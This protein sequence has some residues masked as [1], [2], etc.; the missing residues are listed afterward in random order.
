[1]RDASSERLILPRIKEQPEDFRVDEIPAYEPSGTGDHLFVRFEKRDRTTWDAVRAMA[2]ALGV[3]PRDAG[4]AGMKDKRAVTTQTASFFKARP[5]V[6]LK[7]ELPGIKVLSAVPHGQKLRTGHLAGNQFRIRILDVSAIQLQELEAKA[8]T[9]ITDGIPNAFG[10]QR[11]G[12]EGNN[13]ERARSWLK[14]EW[15]GPKDRRMRTFLFSALQAE[16]F[17]HVLEARWKDGTWNRALLGDVLKKHDTG[18][19]FTCADQAID[20]ER[21]TKGEVSPTGPIFGPKMREPEGAVRALEQSI[22]DRDLEGIDIEKT[23]SLGDGT[24][25]SLR[26]FARDLEVMR[27]EQVHECTVQFMLPK[28]SFATTVLA[29]L[30]P[31]LATDGDPSPE[32]D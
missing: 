3:D 24:R 20:G 2:E 6:A 4:F 21:A 30:V 27:G 14:G 13:A 32:E 28:G 9:V 12:R 31:G 11:F 26:I 10:P 25:R 19:L 29:H 1:M 16:V 5:E 15:R 8:R 7:L 22:L 18:G 23:R 17:N